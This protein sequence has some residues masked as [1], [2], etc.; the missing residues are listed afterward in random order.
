MAKAFPQTWATT[1][2]LKARFKTPV[3]TED[4]VTV[5]GTLTTVAETPSGRVGEFALTLRRSDGQEAITATAWC[6]VG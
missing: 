6:R 1:G 4:I 3:Y 5:S 2:R